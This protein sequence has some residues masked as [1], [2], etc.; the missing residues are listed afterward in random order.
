MSFCVFGCCA[1]C[2]CRKGEVGGRE[3][4]GERERGGRRTTQL[5]FLVAIYGISA[6]LLAD[7]SA[8]FAGLMSEFLR[9]LLFP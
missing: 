9:R 7:Q 1:R 4:E 3:R 2:L 8:V 5:L 6:F